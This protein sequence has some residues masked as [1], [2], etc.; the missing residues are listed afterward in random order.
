MPGNVGLLSIAGKIVRNDYVGKWWIDMLAAGEANPVQMPDLVEQCWQP[1]LGDRRQELVF[2]GID[3][4]REAISEQLRPCEVDYIPNPWLTASPSTDNVSTSPTSQ[5][6]RRAS[7][8]VHSESDWVVAID[9]LGIEGFS[10][11]MKA[12]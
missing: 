3:L 8:S 6:G 11:S 2:I 12:S 1:D 9:R 5:L 10:S 7:R 4:D